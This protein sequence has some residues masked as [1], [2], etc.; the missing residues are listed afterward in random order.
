MRAA[1][2]VLTASL[3]GVGACVSPVSSRVLCSL[4]A[5]LYSL[6]GNPIRKDIVKKVQRALIPW[7]K[8]LIPIQ[9][10]AG[11]TIGATVRHRF[12]VWCCGVK[13]HAL[14]G[15]RRLVRCVCPSA[16]QRY[17]PTGDFFQFSL[18]NLDGFHATGA[19]VVLHASCAASGRGVGGS[20]LFSAD[21][22]LVHA[23]LAVAN[24]P[25]RTRHRWLVR[26]CR[27]HMRAILGRMEKVAVVAAATMNVVDFFSD[28]FVMI[29]VTLRALHAPCSWPG[30]VARARCA[31]PSPHH[32]PLWRTCWSAVVCHW[33]LGL[34]SGRSRHHYR[35]E[36]W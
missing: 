36:S 28:M 26:R 17:Y 14:T 33:A 9:D 11:V 31:A 22:M 23:C 8:K 25:A 20:W 24:P 18:N 12:R 19:Y 10:D 34:G 29:Q 27:Y 32:R 16:T 35:G 4:R 30:R 3:A 6:D 2:H 5:R 1:G 13:R 7:H 15:A 21:G